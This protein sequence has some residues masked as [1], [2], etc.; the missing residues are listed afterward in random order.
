M[1]FLINKIYIIL[2][3]LAI[4]LIQPEASARDN[5]IQYTREN[6]SNYFFGIISAN[7]DYNNRAFKH[8]K[9]VQ[10]LKNRHSQFNIEFIRTLV[11]LEK[12]EQAFAFSRSVWLEDELFFEADLLLGL[13]SFIKRDYVSAEKYFQ[14]L[15]KISQHNLFFE[16]FF[17]NILTAWIKASENNKED[18]FKFFDKIPERYD[19]LKQIQNSFLECYFDTPK[20]II[21]FEKLIN[22]NE[23][24]GFSRYNFF[25][26]NYFLSKNE[27]TAA[28]I[29][30]SNSRSIYNSNLLIKQTEDFILS[31]NSQ[32]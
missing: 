24:Y 23:E 3:L 6:I 18:S 16:D 27:N 25:L 2:F 30:V 5:K 12:F 7:K 29:L 14:R 22:N 21:A 26:A 10:S 9:K 31:G 19:N 13:E 17:G 15:N 11:L 32:K 8:L 20:T 28:E 4:F 1:K